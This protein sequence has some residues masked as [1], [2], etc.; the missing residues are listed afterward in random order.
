MRPPAYSGIL[1]TPLAEDFKSEASDRLM[2]MHYLHGAKEVL[3]L[4]AKCMA[5]E[6]DSRVDDAK[7]SR[8]VRELF[9]LLRWRQKYLPVSSASTLFIIS[10]LS[11]DD[12]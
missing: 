1:T 11:D 12:L 4:T 10:E 2:Q 8:K 5:I 7:T 6:S 9:V 3:R